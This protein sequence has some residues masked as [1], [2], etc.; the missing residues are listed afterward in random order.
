MNYLTI[1]AGVWAICAI[2]AVLFIRGAVQRNREPVRVRTNEHD[3]A[4]KRSKDYGRTI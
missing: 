1:I 3:M 2:C 4:A